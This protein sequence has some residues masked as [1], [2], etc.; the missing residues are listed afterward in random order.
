MFV[1]IF[2][3]S[4]QVKVIPCQCQ[5]DEESE[6]AMEVDVVDYRPYYEQLK[7]KEMNKSE[8]NTNTTT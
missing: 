4:K 3:S 2:L 8:E 6:E 7:E 5:Q 1:Y